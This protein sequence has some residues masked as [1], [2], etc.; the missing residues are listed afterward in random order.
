V[1]RIVADADGIGLARNPFVADIDI[2][3]AR[4]SIPTGVT[5]QGNIA[6]AGCVVIERLEADGRVACPEGEV[7]P[8]IIK[9][10]AVTDSRIGERCPV[11]IKRGTAHGGVT[12]AEAICVE[13]EC[14]I[15]CIIGAKVVEQRPRTGSCIL[16]FTS[17]GK[18]RARADS[19]VSVT[20]CVVPE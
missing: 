1:D 2:E 11:T 5:A 18:E 20:L 10:R 3:I 4:G 15:G 7:F 12:A 9:E 8:G 17:V 16:P 19:R 14:A 6:V 13:S